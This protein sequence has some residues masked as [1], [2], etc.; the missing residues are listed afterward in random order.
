MFF[1]FAAFIIGAALTITFA[2]AEDKPQDT[3]TLNTEKSEQIYITADKMISDNETKSV[4]FIDNVRA[5]QADTVITAD[6]LKIFL[7]K[8][9]GKRN[10]PLSGEESIE[11]IVVNGNVNIRFDNRL[12]VT[13]QAEYITETRILVLSG[14]DSKIISGKDSISGEKITIYRADGRI[15]VESGG[16]KRVE[17][18]FFT[19]EHGIK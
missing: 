17:A 10:N 18:I 16:E 8:G 11:K 12:A 3:G 4:E 13:Q 2:Y 15:D 5:T 1:F 9:L 14:A 6:S 19:G 7:K